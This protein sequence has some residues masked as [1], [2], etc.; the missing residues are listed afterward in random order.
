MI[1]E[2]EDVIRDLRG[3]EGW[4]LVRRAA[5]LRALGAMEGSDEAWSR[6][7]LAVVTPF[8]LMGGWVGGESWSQ[9]RG[10]DRRKGLAGWTRSENGGPSMA[11]RGVGKVTS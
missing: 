1:G 9:S 6:S 7:A 11:P 4:H 5:P 8:R 2:T 3:A 10:R